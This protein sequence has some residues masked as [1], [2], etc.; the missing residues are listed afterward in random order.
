MSWTEGDEHKNV[1]LWMDHRAHT[2]AEFINTTNHK[3]LDSVGGVMSVEM[4]PPKLMWI[5]KVFK[6]GIVML[7]LKAY[8]ISSQNVVFQRGEIIVN[9]LSF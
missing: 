2:E 9:K 8:S 7:L 1:V 6:S 3:V 5:K 4:Q